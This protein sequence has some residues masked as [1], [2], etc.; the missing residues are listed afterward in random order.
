MEPGIDKNDPH[1]YH[2]ISAVLFFLSW[3]LV[4]TGYNRLSHCTYVHIA[5]S[6]NLDYNSIQVLEKKCQCGCKV[7]ISNGALL[8]FCF[9]LI[10][11][12]SART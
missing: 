3:Q 12:H 10:K 7:C 2:S 9:F 8:K 1:K 6:E 5:F 4:L 11:W